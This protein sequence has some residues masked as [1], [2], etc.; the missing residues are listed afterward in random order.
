MKIATQVH[1]YECIH[2]GDGKAHKNWLVSWNLYLP[3]TLFQAF[4]FDRQFFG[5]KT[6]KTEFFLSL[7]IYRNV[8]IHKNN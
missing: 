4:Q 8:Y 5:Q 1:Q 3:G 7:P 2:I 6:K